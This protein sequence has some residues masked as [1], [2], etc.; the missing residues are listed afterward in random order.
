VEP[1][2]LTSP[3]DA[4]RAGR[5]EHIE[6]LARALAGGFGDYLARVP[7]ANQEEAP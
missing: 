6:R 2:F 4:A 1:L 3:D 5:P 7:L